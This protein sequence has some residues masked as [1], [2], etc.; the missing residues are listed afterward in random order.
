MDHTL[1][2]EKNKGKNFT[3][4]R[5]WNALKREAKW[6]TPESHNGGSKQGK[7]SAFGYMTSSNPEILAAKDVAVESLVRPKG[8]NAFKRKHKGKS[9]AAVGLYFTEE[10]EPLKCEAARRISLIEG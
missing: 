4:D 8:T 7:S 5:H 2:L 9:K 3:F 6:R 1:W 10:V